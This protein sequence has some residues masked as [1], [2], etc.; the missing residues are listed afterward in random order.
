MKKITLGKV[1]LTIFILLAIGFV[2]ATV[3]AHFYGAIPEPQVTEQTACVLT[4]K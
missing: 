4:L 2:A 1:L 3:L